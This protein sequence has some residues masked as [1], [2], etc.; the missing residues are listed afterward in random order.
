[1]D[2]QVDLMTRVSFDWIPRKRKL[3]EAPCE[4]HRGPGVVRKNSISTRGCPEILTM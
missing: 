4:P 2:D 1:M 3:P